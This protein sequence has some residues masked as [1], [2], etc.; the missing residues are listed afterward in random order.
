M[1][2]RRL[3]TQH[4]RCT[5]KTKCGRRFKG[6]PGV[7]PC[8]HC[9]AAGRLDK[10][11]DKKPWKKRDRLCYCSAYEWGAYGSPHREGYGACYYAPR[12][13]D[14]EQETHDDGSAVG[15]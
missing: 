12:T 5:S 11:A 4:C 1:V 2:R 3:S 8:P 7:T 9:G 13:E 14:H 15:A 6:F 10:W